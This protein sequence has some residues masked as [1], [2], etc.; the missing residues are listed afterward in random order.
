MATCEWRCTKPGCPDPDYPKDYDAASC[1]ASRG[2]AACKAMR[3]GWKYHYKQVTVRW[4][5]GSRVVKR[6][7]ATGLFECPCGDPTHARRHSQRLVALCRRH[8]SPGKIAAY[9]DTSDEEDV[10]GEDAGQPDV[11]GMLACSAP[12]AWVSDEDD[13]VGEIVIASSAGAKGY[14]GSRRVVNGARANSPI[15]IASSS[16]DPFTMMPRSPSPVTQKSISRSVSSVS[17]LA[18]A[19]AGPSMP[20]PRA[21]DSPPARAN[22]KRKRSSK[23]HCEEHDSE[24]EA[25]VEE[26]KKLREQRKRKLRRMI[27]EYKGDGED[28]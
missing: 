6:N 9:Q 16:P 15:F 14:V 7:E 10:A 4:R 3:H 13:G 26:L 12:Y 27:A 20:T 17:R 22:G 18:N 8:P 28:A 1:M 19:S 21:R 25:L 24:E 5:G 2:P 23:V 11:D